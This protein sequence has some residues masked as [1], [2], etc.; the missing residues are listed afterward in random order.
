MDVHQVLGREVISSDGERLGQVEDVYV[1]SE[2]GEPEFL[3]IASGLLKRR[4][5]AVPASGLTA[6]EETVQI[7]F[8]KDDVKYAPTIEADGELS[9]AE[10]EAL[11]RYYY[12]NRQGG[13]PPSSQND[14]IVD[15][16]SEIESGQHADADSAS[17][18]AMTRSE[19]ELRVVG[20][21]RRPRE[22]VRLRKH[23]VTEYVTMRVPVTREQV[24]VEHEP[25]DDI[26]EPAT[27]S[28]EE[29]AESA[30]TLSSEEPIVEKRV[31][32]KE[33]IRL[34]A[35]AVTEGERVSQPVRKE[36]VDVEGDP[37]LLKEDDHEH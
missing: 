8:G 32:P 6:G 27:D 7:A 20:H 35:E 24:E 16:G 19:E 36:H 13:Q 15:D 25:I 26:A 4:R 22:R 34:D 9:E 11:Y 14:G 18:D 31:V 3:I 2:T 5:H 21:Q 10:E 37:A 17:T 33:R 12:Y 28:D 1:D 23:Q 29:D 30:V